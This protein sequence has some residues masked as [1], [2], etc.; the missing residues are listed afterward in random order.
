MSTRV[1]VHY[2][3]IV[4]YYYITC[5]VYIKYMLFKRM[6]LKIRN[7]IFLPRLTRSADVLPSPL[8]WAM[9]IS[10][11]VLIFSAHTFLKSL[12]CTHIGSWFYYQRWLNSHSL[13]NA[14]TVLTLGNFFLN[15]SMPSFPTTIEGLTSFTQNS[16]R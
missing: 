8:V 6:S 7:L 3:Q 13:L 2:I 15:L 11:R 16:S 12:L 4:L 14:S 9:V 1:S 10:S 5:K